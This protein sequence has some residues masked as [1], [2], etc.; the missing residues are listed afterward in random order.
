[1]PQEGNAPTSNGEAD[2]S[3]REAAEE[4]KP[5]KRKYGSSD[6]F[7]ARQAEKYRA[8]KNE[9]TSRL[10]EVLELHGLPTSSVKG[11]RKGN[12][13]I[14]I[15]PLLHNTIRVVKDLLAKKESGWSP[16]GAS[17]CSTGTKTRSA[18]DSMHWSA[19]MA[20][21][22]IAT[23]SL[24]VPDLVVTESNAGM[25]E[26]C[27]LGECP[28]YLGRSLFEFFHPADVPELQNAMREIERGLPTQ[29]RARL[30]RTFLADDGVTAQSE[31]TWQTVK[32][33]HASSDKRAVFML[34]ELA[35]NCRQRAKSPADNLSR[36]TTSVGRQPQWPGLIGDGSNCATFS[37]PLSAAGAVNRAPHQS[38]ICVSAEKAF[39]A[40]FADPVPKPSVGSVIP[41]P[42]A[43]NDLFMQ[44]YCQRNLIN[45][46][47]AQPP[48]VPEAQIDLSMLLKLHGGALGGAQPNGQSH[49]SFLPTPSY[50][51]FNGNA[52]TNALNN[53]NGN[54]LMLG[55]LSGYAKQG[56]GAVTGQQS[57]QLTATS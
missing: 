4:Q 28:G 26:F 45:F 44:D 20:S 30:R 24:R 46:M 11:K 18:S 13:I 50:Q 32:V 54:Q 29:F 43:R 10:A 38:D 47:G 40:S 31:H 15:G 14:R 9:H 3:A 19:F 55:L 34:F 37:N 51:M 22:A 6:T 39:T 1:M 33:M 23:L 52:Q 27:P 53:I 57:E 7:G 8:R 36:Q 17:S 16:L 12:T 21:S 25:R 48:L 35:D 49:A 56:T 42:A 2:A 41:V 5:T